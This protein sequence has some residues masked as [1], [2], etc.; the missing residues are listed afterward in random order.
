MNKKIIASTKELIMYKQKWIAVLIIFLTVPMICLAQSQYFTGDGGKGM[1]LGILVP[2][3]QGLNENQSYLPSLIQGVLVSNISKY[4]AI[5]V[6]DRVALDRVI[7]ETLDPTYEDNLEIVRLGHVAQVGYMMTGKITRTGSGYSLQINVT[8]TTPNANTIASYSGTCTANQLDDHSA[9]HRASL[10]LLTKM[11]VKLTASAKKELE[12]AS[13]TQDRN[14]QTALAQG[15]VANQKGQ[16]VEAFSY[17]LNASSF[18]QVSTEALNR[19]SMATTTIA[20]GSLGTQIRNDIQ[21]RNEWI[22]LIKE[23]NKYFLDN[24]QYDVLE[25]YFN[26]YLSVDSIDYDRQNATISFSVEVGVNKERANA[27]NKII[28]DINNGLA[29]TGRQSAWQIEGVDTGIRESFRESFD[30]QLPENLGTLPFTFVYIFQFDLINENGIR[31]ATVET[32]PVVMNKF[33]VVNFSEPIRN[34]NT[35]TAIMW[36][37]GIITKFG[38]NIPKSTV[39]NITV[40]NT[41]FTISASRITNSLS[42][43]L[44]NISV[45]KVTPDY[46]YGEYRKDIFKLTKQGN[47]IIP[48]HI[49]STTQTSSN[50]SQTSSNT[51]QPRP[52]SVTEIKDSAFYNKNLTIVTIPDGVIKI[53]YFAYAT[54]KLTSVIIPN[55]VIEIGEYAFADNLLTSITI[56]N[57]VTKIGKFAFGSNNITYITIGSNVSIEKDSFNLGFPDF[58][59]KNGKKAGTYTYLN[60]KWS[61]SPK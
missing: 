4:T 52:E 48:V 49:G 43:K 39:D 17:F 22:K 37:Q 13:S 24:P 41:K 60:K 21:Q 53:G 16:T 23:T 8:D 58:Y 11:G 40:N 2:Q 3:S 10:G 25:V 27:I 45:Y 44:R 42:I 50:T 30:S 33:R 7:G 34:F 14:A 55:S 57:S 20:T 26:S 9:I 46:F 31:L 59:N 19:M 32:F 28:S 36:N 29:R 38:F 47:N 54:N 12:K 51:S 56:P 35:M 5:S 15:I 18:E 6:L 61:Y 1:R